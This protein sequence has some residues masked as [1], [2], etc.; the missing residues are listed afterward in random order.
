MKVVI[1]LNIL[2]FVNYSF[3]QIPIGTWRTHLSYNC[4]IDVAPANDVVYCLTT[5]GLFAFNLNDNSIRKLDK[6]NGLSDVTIKCIKYIKEKKSLVI[7]YENGNIDVI[8]NNRIFNISD[9]KQKPI[10]GNKSINCIEYY[11]GKTYL[12][13]GFG[14]VVI[15]IDKYEVKE[16]YIIGANATNVEVQDIAFSNEK[17]YAASTN[18]IYYAFLQGVNLANYQNW[19]KILNLSNISTKSYMQFINRIL[20]TTIS[21][22]SLTTIRGK[23]WILV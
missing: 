14:I 13:T 6:V 23:K 20:G 22:T 17:I 21:Y 5:G 7:G 2:F 19:S 18:G 4:A 10:I 3:S 12:G 15:D 11:N 1:I 16:T 8:K 9:I